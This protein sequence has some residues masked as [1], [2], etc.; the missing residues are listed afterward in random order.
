MTTHIHAAV[1]QVGRIEVVHTPGD[2]DPHYRICLDGEGQVV[3]IGTEDDLTDQL[4]ALIASAIE[5]VR[6]AVD[7]DHRS[8]VRRLLVDTTAVAAQIARLPYTSKDPA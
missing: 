7:R 3:L 1:A 2:T 5:S 6:P 4:P 8:N